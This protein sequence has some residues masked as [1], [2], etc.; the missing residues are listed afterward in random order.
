MY[1][2]V[3]PPACLCA[4]VCVRECVCR[5]ICQL[6]SQA[7]DISSNHSRR[8]QAANATCPSQYLI[9]PS[10]IRTHTTVLSYVSVCV[11]VCV[12]Y[13][14]LRMQMRLQ[15][16]LT[17]SRAKP[18]Q[19]QLSR[20]EPIESLPPKFPYVCVHKCLCVCACQCVCACG[21]QHLC[22]IK[23]NLA[24]KCQIANCLI[25]HRKDPLLL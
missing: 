3:H 24:F 9:C 1:T 15:P 13:L 25:K 11:R 19:A 8:L 12:L 23:F 17:A 2:G 20:G 6:R 7:H 5:G 16:Y 14:Y 10:C 22:T 21:L 4:S 18:S